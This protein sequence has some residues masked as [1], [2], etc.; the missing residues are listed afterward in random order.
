M[1][2]YLAAFLLSALVALV[3]TP[4]VTRVAHIQGWYDMPTGGRKI[5]ALPIPRVGGVAVVTAFFAPLAGLLIYI[6]RI[7]GFLYAD[8]R[9]LT[10]M[11]GGAAIIVALGLF[12]DLR[13]ATA[14]TK[15]VVQ[16]VVAL[17]MW[18]AGFR[19]EL[20]GNPFGAPL[21]L[22]V[23]SLPLT[24]LWIVGVVNALNLIDGLDGLASGTALMASI[25]LFG[26]AFVDNAVLLC[27]LMAALGGALMGFLFYNFNPA[28]VFLGDS[29]S[30]FLGFVL[31][32]VSLWTQVKAATTIA[33]LIPVV[34]LGLPI[35]DTTLSFVRRLARGQSPFRSDREHVHH[36][37][38]ALGLSHRHA[39]IT[40]YTLS[41]I[42]ALG[43]LSLLN[44]DS[45]RRTI[46][47]SAMVAVVCIVLRRIGVTRVPGPFHTL[48]TNEDAARD[49]VRIGARRIRNAV[50]FERA[51]QAT[52]EVLD[53]LGYEEVQLVLAHP[54]RTDRERREQLFF[55]RR[56]ANAGWRLRDP[57]LASDRRGRF[58]LTEEDVAF[59]ELSVLRPGDGQRTL[60]AELALEV[61]RDALIDFS[62][63]QLDG[64]D[65]A[66]VVSLP[67]KP[68][69]ATVLRQV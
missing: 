11:C 17:G 65:P 24:T 34:A 6:N 51:W 35:L 13:G 22:G 19:I 49:L 12:D 66:R 14:K 48:S 54:D 58:P 4:V 46:V 27:V 62:I 28:K 38:L 41:A 21:T 1:L 42:F 31:A 60:G 57:I 59:G 23:L 56:H 53:E 32:S 64:F 29:G 43:A 69:S 26:M 7:S 16:V 44:G 3:L 9:M 63:A 52:V 5:H 18:W 37:L 15:L 47:L 33:L 55:W 67:Q 68:A 40:L 20:L 36:R 61:T 10:A 30:M 8:F 2:T 50:D 25:V 45:I 39:V